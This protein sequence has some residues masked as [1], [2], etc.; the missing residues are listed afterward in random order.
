MSGP[1]SPDPRPASPGTAAFD[2]LPRPD[3]VA[4]LLSVCS[5]PAW[6]EAVADGRPYGDLDALL[7]AADTALDR[8]AAAGIADALAGHPRIGERAVHSP[9]SAREQAG[10]AGAP[11]AVRAAIAEGNAEYERRFGHVYLVCASGRD[12]DELL[13]VLRER[14]GNSAE[15]EARRTRAEL[16]AINRLRLTGLIVQDR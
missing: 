1:S 13:A 15:E 7:A 4:A 2:H 3:A 10:M 9:T 14:L 8:L 11:D 16:A 5:S 6:A 12:A